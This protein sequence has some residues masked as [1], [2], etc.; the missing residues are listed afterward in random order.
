MREIL[1]IQAGQCGNQIGSRVSIFVTDPSNN[2]SV[3]LS[4]YLYSDNRNS[5]VDQ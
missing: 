2:I 4:I 3:K 5:Y 1:N